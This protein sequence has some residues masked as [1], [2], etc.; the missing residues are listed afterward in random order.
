MYRIAS[1]KI[2]LIALIPTGSEQADFIMAS[3]WAKSITKPLTDEESLEM[4]FR[5]TVSA[6]LFPR[7]NCRL[8][9]SEIGVQFAAYEAWQ[10][11]RFPSPVPVEVLHEHDFYIAKVMSNRE[12]FNARRGSESYMGIVLGVPKVGDMVCVLLG[13]DTP[14]VLRPLGNGEWHFVAEAYVHGLM[15]GEAMEK[16][17]IDKFDYQEFSII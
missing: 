15:D 11:R 7:P 5:R 10:D 1:S 14:F 6:D 17:A 9:Q 12:F 8:N 4:A 16:V 13:G 2:P 3:I